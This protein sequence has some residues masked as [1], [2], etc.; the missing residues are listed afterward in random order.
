MKQGKIINAYNALSRLYMQ[1]LP[2]KEA[3]KIFGLR[4]QMKGQYDFQVEREKQFLEKYNGYFDD[5]GEV[6]FHKREEAKQFADAVTEL[7]EME[8]EEQ[9][10]PIT[11]KMDALNDLKIMPGDI[12]SLDGIVIFE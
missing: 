3:Y 5:N 7:S 12:E 6:K 4:K 11:M 8:V 1:Q 9:I 2:I 10:T